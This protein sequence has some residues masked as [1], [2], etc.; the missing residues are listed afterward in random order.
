RA[1][2]RG[3]WRRERRTW[4]R[5]SGRKGRSARDPGEHR[6]HLAETGRRR[7]PQRH[8]DA[9]R[10]RFVPRPCGVI[11][12]MLKSSLRKPGAPL[13]LRSGRAESLNAAASGPAVGSLHERRRFERAKEDDLSFEL[14]AELL[15]RSA[16]RLAHEGEAV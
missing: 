12:R 2:T 6:P 5:V 16:P 9:I 3:R 10:A 7:L 1:N 13:A 14:D 8:A 15:V 11:R 4:P